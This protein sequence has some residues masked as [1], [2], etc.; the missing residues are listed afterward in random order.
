M[1][2]D[3]ERYPMLKAVASRDKRLAERL[4]NKD[5]SD[6]TQPG[7][8]KATARKERQQTTDKGGPG[9][10][11][12][13]LLKSIGINPL[14]GCPC[15]AFGQK[16]DRWGVAGCRHHFDEIVAHFRTYQSKY[17]WAT[18]FKAASLAAMNGLAFKLNWL[19]PLPDL[20]TEAIQRAEAKEAADRRT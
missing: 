19:D 2:L 12:T 6:R 4:T 13:L 9:I 1:N 18:K 11:L 15:K 5:G 17:G 10:E 14:I 7:I 20:I 3:L 8:I 16:M